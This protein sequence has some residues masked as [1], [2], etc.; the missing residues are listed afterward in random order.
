MFGVSPSSAMMASTR[1]RAP[2]MS[3][4]GPM[5]ANH[6]SHAAQAESPTAPPDPAETLDDPTGLDKWT[7]FHEAVEKL[8]A[9]EREVA[10]L[11]FYHGWT[12][13][14]VAELLGVDVR[15]VQRHWLSARLSLREALQGDMPE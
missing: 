10:G 9:D 7:A 6:A 5:G 4:V 8:P 1:L 12:Q 13:A 14:E 2:S 11:V 15:T 3:L